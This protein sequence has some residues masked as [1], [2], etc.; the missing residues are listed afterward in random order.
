M[1]NAKNIDNIE[2]HRQYRNVE[3]NGHHSEDQ[4]NNCKVNSETMNNVLQ[5]SR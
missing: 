5:I 2:I 4:L 3:I 1:H